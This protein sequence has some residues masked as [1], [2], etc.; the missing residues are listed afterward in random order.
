MTTEI[1]TQ[2]ES[3]ESRKRLKLLATVLTTGVVIG[4]AA[5]VADARNPSGF[6]TTALGVV[7]LLI[8]LFVIGTAVEMARERSLRRLS[9][10]AVIIVATPF[11]LIALVE[12]IF[13]GA[14][15]GHDAAGFGVVYFAWACV[16]SGLSLLVVAGV[17]FIVESR[18]Q[19]LSA[20]E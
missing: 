15:G 3:L 2:S 7:E 17:R 11:V 20:N 14:S 10:I 4:F 9:V 18:K 5:V 19:R 6:L 13:S 12:V 16:A 8:C 1:D